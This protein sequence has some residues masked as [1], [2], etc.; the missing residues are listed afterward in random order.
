MR[1]VRRR[2]P[3]T[4][5]TQAAHEA[6]ARH[7]HVADLHAR[8]VYRGAWRL[9]RREPLRVWAAALV[10]LG[11]GLVL[12]VGAGI[13]LDRFTEDTVTEGVAF[14]LAVAGIAA[15]LGTLGTVFYAGL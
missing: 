12:G 9:Y 13:F 2:T 14:A 15:V 11:P 1:N 8:S 5:A 4:D 6:A 3:S 10:L 7:P